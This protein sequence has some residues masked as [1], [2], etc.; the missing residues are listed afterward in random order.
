MELPLASATIVSTAHHWPLTKEI[1]AISQKTSKQ[2]PANHPQTTS[3]TLKKRS[4]HCSSRVSPLTFPFRR[5]CL[6]A[7]PVAGRRIHCRPIWIYTYTVRENCFCG[8]QRIIIRTHQGFVARQRLS[9]LHQIHGNDKH[10][11]L[12]NLIKYAEPSWRRGGHLQGHSRAAPDKS[13]FVA[14]KNKL[15]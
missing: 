4:H 14:E 15:L 11:A 13:A 12:G 2:S 1:P 3:S 8:Q 6:H 7:I 5:H 9:L 10:C